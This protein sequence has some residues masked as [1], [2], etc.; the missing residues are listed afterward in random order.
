MPRVLVVVAHPDD[1]T[2]AIGARMGRFAAARFVHVTDGAPPDGADAAAH[3]FASLDEYRAA[4]TAELRNAFAL[5]GLNPGQLCSLAVPDQQ[6][7]FHMAEISRAL[8]ELIGRY[9]PE[10]ILT[11]P[12]EGGHPD[13]D[14]C[15]FAVQH[16]I[17]LSARR[18]AIIECP[19]Y[20]AGPNGMQTEAF[21][22]ATRNRTPEISLQLN[23]H[24]VRRKRERL[25]CFRS[26]A[27]TL[28]SF[29]IEREL[30]RIAPA[31]DFTRPPHQPPV[32]YDGHPWGMTSVRFC[33]LASAAARELTGGPTPSSFG[34]ESALC[35]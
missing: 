28:A 7:A 29:P 22:P 5:A 16:A 4:R 24:E 20:H 3:G 27:A 26:Q 33:E 17:L 8:A 2:L 15:A 34:T 32:F 21:L 31:Y 18:P 35:R 23:E 14:A 11:H 30:F 25:A 6:A 12:Y 10:A 19:F 13:H 1:E 9:A